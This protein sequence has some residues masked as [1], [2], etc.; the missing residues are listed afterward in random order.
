MN[1]TVGKQNYEINNQIP[2]S[3]YIDIINNRTCREEKI[4]WK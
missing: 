1:G 4:Y 3:R 2:K